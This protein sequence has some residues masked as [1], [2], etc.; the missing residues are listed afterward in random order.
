MF[1]YL[2]I[3]FGFAACSLGASEQPECPRVYDDTYAREHRLYFPEPL[4]SQ[5]VVSNGTS[6]DKSAYSDADLGRHIFTLTGDDKHKPITRWMDQNR[7]EIRYPKGTSCQTEYKFQIKPGTTYLGGAPV[8]S[9]E[10]VF[11]MP[12]GIPRG[13]GVL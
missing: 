10:L 3:L 11:R 8:E 2:L 9:R 1:R 7:L 5:T 12:P 6:A 13:Y 4:V